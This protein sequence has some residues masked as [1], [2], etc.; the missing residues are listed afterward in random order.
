[1]FM[2][3]IPDSDQ[4]LRKQPCQRL[5]QRG[6]DVFEPREGLMMREEDYLARFAFDDDP[7]DPAGLLVIEIVVGMRGIEADQQPVIVLQ[8]EVTRRLTK[9]RQDVVEIRKAAGIHLMV[10]VQR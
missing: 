5:L 1:M 9:R 6:L 8:G 10:S 3:P 2:P 7:L 4:P